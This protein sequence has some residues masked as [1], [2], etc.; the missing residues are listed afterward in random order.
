F[1][2]VI[3]YVT[4]DGNNMALHLREKI[5]ASLECLGIDGGEIMTTDTHVVNGL[6]PARLGYHPV[7]EAMDHNVVIDL[8]RATVERAKQDLEEATVSASS[9]S[10]R[11]K[12]LGS[13]SLE[14]LLSF[15]YGVAKLVAL[16]MLMLFLGSNLVGLMII[17]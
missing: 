11:V 10:V 8:V 16:Y 12:S 2:Q 14:S 15:M 13:K 9:G 3:A 1:G 17:R 7:G 5:L 4:I 6:V